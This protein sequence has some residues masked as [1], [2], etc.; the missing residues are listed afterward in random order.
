MTNNLLERLADKS[1]TK[2]ELKDKIKDN[3][4]I[5]PEIL[6]GVSSDKASIRYGCGKILM[7]LS[8][9]NPEKLY[10]HIDFFITLLDSKH[11]ILTWQ[12]MAV[13]A[14]LTR[15]DTKNRFEEI[16]DKY[17]SF[18][19]DEYMV[20]V[21]N[22]VGNSSKIALAKPRL[23]QKITNELL[24]VDKIKTTPHLTSEC[25]KVIAQKAIGSFDKFFN[26]IENKDEVI[27]FVK[28]QVNSTR[29][30]L[31]TDAEKFLQKWSS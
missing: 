12:A 24:K 14:N 25:R 10:P 13:I 3:F 6:N 11:R 18:L 29:K 21:A 30:N 31:K 8:E 16:F 5:L 28:K 20:T 2:E 1:I 15:V 9:E 17:Y 27:S 4:D 23:T 19:N 26:Q 7:D 22:V